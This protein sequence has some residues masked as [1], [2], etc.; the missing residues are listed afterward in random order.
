MPT[1]D[2]FKPCK[3]VPERKHGPASANA[4]TIRA[5]LRSGIECARYEC[6]DAREANSY[7]TLLRGAC[8]GQPVTVSQRGRCVYLSRGARDGR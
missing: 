3:G 8:K 6:K 1:F 4:A 2:D 7:A 5:F